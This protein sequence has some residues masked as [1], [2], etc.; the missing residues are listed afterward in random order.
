MRKMCIRDRGNTVALTLDIDVQEDV[1][2]ILAETVESM[3]AEDDIDRG[4]AAAVVQVGTG[5]VLSLASYP[6]CLLYTS[7][8]V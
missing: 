6:T 2:R 8:C 7:R 5:E 4:A 1:E 3:T